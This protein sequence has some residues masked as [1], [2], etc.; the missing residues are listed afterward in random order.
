MYPRA[1]EEL[2]EFFR[3]LPG[4]GTKTAERYAF[5]LLDEE[6]QRL[7]DYAKN[8]IQ[9]QDRIKFCTICNHM[10]EDE[11]CDICQSASRD[12]KIL[13]VVQS[14]KDVVAM[15]KTSEYHGK[16]HVLKGVISAS[17]GIMPADIEIDSLLKRINS[18]VSEVILATN[19]T[20]DGETTAL[21]IG[22]LLEN[23][24]VLVTRL[25]HGLPMGG[26][27]DYADELTLIKAIEGRKKV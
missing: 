16:Y 15:E 10:C 17:K 6:P 23:K 8:M 25:A 12:S 18:E 11:V 13:C 21:Y 2:V 22:K 27:L 7:D 3:I 20:V 24:G 5:A 4:V 1:F 19:P 9:I 26:H 14:S